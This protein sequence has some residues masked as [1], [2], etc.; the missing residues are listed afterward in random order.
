MI[1]I[2]R[3]EEQAALLEGIVSSLT[4]DLEKIREDAQSVQHC[5]TEHAH[6]AG[7]QVHAHTLQ[8]HTAVWVQ[9]M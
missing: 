6:S 1:V 4:E 2:D 5:L 9:L 3:Q 8:V 7:T